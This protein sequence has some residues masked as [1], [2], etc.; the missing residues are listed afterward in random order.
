MVL[1]PRNGLSLCSGAGGLDMGLMLAE[2]DYHTRC[3]V[4]W[5]E[6]P[7]ASLIAAQRAG[8]FAPAP[9]W[10]DVT[11]FDAKP[12]AGAIDT[13][14]AGYPC[15]PFS[16]AGQRKGE[17]DERHLWPDIE[18]II[19]ELGPS[20]RWCFFENVAGHLTL[21]LDTV[22]RSLHDM[23]FRVAGGLFSA[24][25]VGASHERQRVFIVAFRQDRVSEDGNYVADSGCY[26]H[27]EK[28]GDSGEVS[29][30]SS[31][32][33]AVYGPD[34]FDRCSTELADTSSRRQCEP[35]EGQDQQQ[36]RDEAIGSVAELAHADGGNPSAER[37][38]RGGKQRLHE[39][40]RC[41]TQDMGNAESI[42]RGERGAKHGVWIGGDA[43]IGSVADM[44]HTEGI[45]AGEPNHTASAKSRQ[46]P[47]QVAGGGGLRNDGE[48]AYAAGNRRQ[49]AERG[50]S[51]D[52]RSD[53]C[54]P[55]VDD[56]DG[57]RS[58]GWGDDIGE[59]TGERP[60][61]P[62]GSF[63]PGPSAAA[64]WAS[65]ISMA[66]DLAPAVSLGDVKRACDYFAKM[67]AAGELEEAAA[68]PALC[69]MV[70]GLAQRSRALRLLG[71]GVV[72]LEAAYAWRTL[73][74]AHGLGWVD[75]GSDAGTRGTAADDL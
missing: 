50:Q 7:R 3:F 27:G 14:I 31:G 30:I 71:N 74:S 33:R 66:P 57:A 4:E 26:L 61:W 6:Y 39:G 54:Q 42:G 19:G 37:Q 49:Q 1:P 64:E 53:P 45:G 21:G 67:V 2:P 56:A 5:E 36:G 11:T 34:V 48:L 51:Q 65:V 69:R 41:D 20:L 9:I 72:P 38:Q 46:E 32:Q 58:Q 18:R 13:I 8:Y 60:A 24:E 25:E 12:L 40:G 55:H 10:D 73:S 62:P 28:A 70:D 29:G 15:Q 47:R 44:A 52:V 17:S 68:E 63:P 59:H 43:T 75:L 23:G 22:A 16:Q 35:R